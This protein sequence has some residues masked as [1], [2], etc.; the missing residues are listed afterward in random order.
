ML[1]TRLPLMLTSAAMAMSLAASCTAARLDEN[2]EERLQ[3]TRGVSTT[4]ATSDSGPIDAGPA[5]VPGGDSALLGMRGARPGTGLDADFRDRILGI[6]PSVADF[7]GAA[8]GY[9]AVMVLAI[10]AE[11][12]RS[13]APGRLAAGV[14][15][16]TRRGESCRTFIQCRALALTNTDLD[17]DGASGQVELLENGDPGEAGFSIVEF[18]GDG[19]LEVTDQTTAQAS[20]LTNPPNPPDAAFGPHGDGVLTIGTLLPV[21]GPDGA[22]ARAALAGAGLAVDEINAA[23]GVLGD[24]MT[25]IPDESG[26]GSNDGTAAAVG[27]LLGQGADAVIGGTNYG[28][29]SVALAPLTDAGVVLFSPTDTA[30]AL[31]IAPDNGRFFRLS[32]STD[33]EG[34]VLGTL[35]A[36]DGFTQVAIASGPSDDDLELAA[37]VA[38]ALNASGATVTATVLVD[39]AADAAASSLELLVG[40]PQAIVV[41][42]PTTTA[43]ALIGQLIAAGKGPA[44]LP[45]YGTAANMT[46]ELA[47]EVSAG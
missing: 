25:L 35:V 27:R 29:T 44:S 10:S 12:A 43:A 17:Y 33:L 9:D 22:A 28:I 6:D 5:P 38:A 26:D 7:D 32:P 30:R 34:R 4:T 13:D 11:A 8:E 21:A 31:S 2:P 36:N 20:D 39:S 46:P 42:T 41:V 15:A 1:R 18:R 40:N 37:D 16:T 23:N 45:I 24:L 19:T 14:I 3:S 47:T